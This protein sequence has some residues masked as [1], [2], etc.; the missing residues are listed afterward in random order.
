[1]KLLQLK[2]ATRREHGFTL[3]E[4]VIAT[5]VVGLVFVASIGAL[6]F[7]EVQMARDR[8]RGIMLDF[9][10][11]LTETLKGLPFDQIAAGV[12]INTLYNGVNSGSNI[13]IPANNNWIS[14]SNTNYQNFHPDLVLMGERNPEMRMIL[15][16]TPAGGVDWSKQIEIDLRW[17]PPL[18]QGTKIS[19]RLDTARFKDLY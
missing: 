2:T 15:V 11:H 4:A 5:L 3:V 1:M 10:M 16:T 12:P 19:A 6:S 14:L 18:G 13:R 8:E 7:S 17:D 9:G